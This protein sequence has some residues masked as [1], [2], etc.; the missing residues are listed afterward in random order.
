MTSPVHPAVYDSAAT[1]SNSW[2]IKPRANRT[3]RCLCIVPR[4]CASD[5][6]KY[7]KS[8]PND[9]AVSVPT[10]RRSPLAID[11][12][13]QRSCYGRSTPNRP[14]RASSTQYIWRRDGRYS[15]PLP[16][17]RRS[18]HT[19]WSTP[20]CRRLPTVAADTTESLHGAHCTA[21]SESFTRKRPSVHVRYRPPKK[22]NARKAP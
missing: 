6:A 5:T 13:C 3:N 19:D 10:P 2:G 17:R 1:A 7:W 8:L 14:E 11:R 20:P 16:S 22:E 4:F 15:T 21:S 9:G 18:R 12:W